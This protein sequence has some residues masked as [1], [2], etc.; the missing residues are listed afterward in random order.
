MRHE[1]KVTN[2][3]NINTMLWQM[4]QEVDR[5]IACAVAASSLRLCCASHLLTISTAIAVVARA[6]H[7]GPSTAQSRAMSYQTFAHPLPTQTY[8]THRIQ[9][10]AVPVNSPLISCVLCS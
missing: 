8:C 5:G 7:G 4:A 10:F 2:L 1:H 6:G 3:I 9:Q